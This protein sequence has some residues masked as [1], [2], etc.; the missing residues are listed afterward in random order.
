MARKSLDDVEARKPAWVRAVENPT[1][2]NID[3]LSKG[4][5][6]WVASWF[7]G[8]EEPSDKPE[9]H[10]GSV[11]MALLE[12][13][14]KGVAIHPD[15]QGEDEEVGFL[16]PESDDESEGEDSAEAE[17]GVSEENLEGLTRDELEKRASSEGI[18]APE[19][20]ENKQAIIDALNQA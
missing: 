3:N 5:L 13:L 9:N 15:E 7:A 19:K 1:E 20:F 12:K 14:V 11:S 2:E 17:E 6:V 4:E 8:E 18:Q 16:A 10:T